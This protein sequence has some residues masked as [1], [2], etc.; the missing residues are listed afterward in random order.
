MR[1]ASKEDLLADI[2]REH[3]ALC[4]LLAEIPESRHEEPGVWGDA[5]SVHDLVAHLAEWHALFLLWH[6]VGEAG[7]SPRMPAPG[8]K[9]N[10][11]PRLNRAIQAKHHVRALS[12]V[13]DDFSATYARVLGLARELSEEQL[14]E[15][16]HFAWT[17]KNPLVTYLGANTA[18][19][20]RFAMQVLRRWLGGAA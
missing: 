3:D 20:Y 8:Y 11:T 18:S 4:A 17:G 10:E 2:A 19:H 9:W 15:P 13:R 7:G 6:E 12:E 5:W 1:Y 14:L 16:G